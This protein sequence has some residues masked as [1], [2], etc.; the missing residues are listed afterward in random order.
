[1]F[2]FT[3]RELL[4]LTLS[5]GLSLGWWLEHRAHADAAEDARMLA[6]FSANGPGCSNEASWCMQL[7]AKYGAHRIEMTHLTNEDEAALGLDIE[8]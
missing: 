1:M 4:I 8:Q 7:Q 2:T 3:I 6:H 5:V